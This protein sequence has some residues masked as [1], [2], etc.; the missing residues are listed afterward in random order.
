ME[1]EQKRKLKVT[2]LNQETGELKQEFECD[3]IAA[4]TYLDMV[5]DMCGIGR[6]I[7]GKPHPYFI[8]QSPIEF[9]KLYEHLLKD[10]DDAKPKNN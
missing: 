9:G 6:L 10:D 5:E 7:V 4:L 2:I 8:F 3:T 1:N